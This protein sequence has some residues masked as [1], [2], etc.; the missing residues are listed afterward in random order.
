MSPFV[1]AFLLMV[2]MG[3]MTAGGQIFLKLG[4]KG[5]ERPSGVWGMILFCLN[6]RILTGLFLALTA[7]LVYIRAL[8][9]LGLSGTYGLNGLSY[10]FVF[11]FSR[12]FLN[13]KGSLMHLAGLILI[14]GGIA[15]WSI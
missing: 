5:R 11:A 1:Q 7:P 2:L 4:M 6:I 15:L 14:A 12:I 9:F 3:V 10:F 13:E 8:A